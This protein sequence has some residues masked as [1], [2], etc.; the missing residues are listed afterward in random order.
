MH[1]EFNRATLARR[2]PGSAFK[3][4]VYLTAL[5]NGRTPASR[6]VDAPVTYRNWTP[7]NFDEK[8]LGEMSMTEALALSINSIAVRLCLELGPDTVAA[9]A[10]R[11][12]ITSPLN[13]VPS[14][15]LG[16]SEVTLFELTKAYVPFAA[17]GRGA[18]ARGIESVRAVNGDVLYAR[19]GSGLGDVIDAPAAGA[20]N[21]MLSEAMRTGTGKS[22][23]LAGRP[24]AGKTGTTQD[25]KDAWFVGY[26]GQLVTGVWVGNDSAQPMKKITGGTLPAAIWKNFMETATASDPVVA[27]PGTNVTDSPQVATNEGTSAFD[28]LLSSLFESKPDDKP[29]PAPITTN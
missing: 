22:A 13:A 7:Q 1:S 17:G 18:I 10:R 19:R 12:G 27:L 28:Q 29:K 16:T 6:V 9:T 4:F 15:A 11:L 2:Q 8:Y 3:P 24:A 26:T 25:F 5:E 21:R 23:A 14:L 20:M